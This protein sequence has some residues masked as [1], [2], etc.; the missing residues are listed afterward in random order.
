MNTK[1]IVTSETVRSA[2]GHKN[3]LLVDDDR[4]ALE[5]GEFYF[6]ECGWD[7]HK[8]E[9]VDEAVRIF[10]W[11]QIDLVIA[12]FHMPD[13]SGADL[14]DLVSKFKT[15]PAFVFLTTDP[16]ITEIAELKKTHQIDVWQKPLDPQLLYEMI[17]AVFG[18]R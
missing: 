9:N 12:D 13:K 11:S 3:V 7:V 6:S 15:P 14:F 10:A 2:V 4:L 16:T 18:S 8:A 1:R 17:M 5:I